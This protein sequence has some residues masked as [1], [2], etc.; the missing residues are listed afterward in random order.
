VWSAGLLIADS[1]LESVGA[2]TELADAAERASADCPKRQ[3]AA[4]YDQ[5]M[6]LHRD[7]VAKAAE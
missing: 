1:I 3:P 2:E 5:C 6:M 4:A 7:L